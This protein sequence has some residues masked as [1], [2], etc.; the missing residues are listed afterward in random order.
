MGDDTKLG[1][2]IADLDELIDALQADIKSGGFDNDSVM[3]L[4]KAWTKVV[5]LARGG[6][7][8]KKASAY[9]IMK[10]EPP[11]IPGKR[12]AELLRALEAFSNLLE[13]G[14]TEGDFFNRADQAMLNFV[15]DYRQHLTGKQET[16]FVH[17]L[18]KWMSLTEEKAM[19]EVVTNMDR[20]A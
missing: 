16:D 12:S 11:K 13:K 3:W 18:T 4:I 19:Q 7:Y 20:S 9:F 2:A 17:K 1:I 10:R 8:H 6:G 15:W 5:V 14:V